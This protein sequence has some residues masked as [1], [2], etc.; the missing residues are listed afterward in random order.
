MKR[1]ISILG[2]LLVLMT[3]VVSVKAVPAEK[4]C[5][6]SDNGK[7]IWT[8]GYATTE[9]GMDV[10]DCDGASENLKEFWCDGDKSMPDNI[11]CSDFNAVCVT[12][13]DKTV[14]DYCACEKG[15]VFDDQKSTC[16]A[17]NEVPEFGVLAGTLA[18]IGALGVFV[19]S[20][21]Q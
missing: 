19:I 8:A 15:Y 18:V 10:D 4:Y 1:F 17:D 7:D 14:P 9:K 2:I 11:K 5:L 3:L 21:K 13:G 6:D 20:R 12:V 16:V